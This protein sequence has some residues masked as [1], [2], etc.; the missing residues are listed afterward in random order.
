MTDQ[1]T[2]EA[3]D[4]ADLR[5]RIALAIHR[6]DNVH[7]LS[8]N[9][10]PSHHHYGE[11]DA[12]LAVRD[13]EMERMKVLVAASE[14]PGHA[15]RMAA[16]YADKAIENGERA[17]RLEAE[18]A[19]AR[20]FAAEMRDFCSPHAIAADYADRLVEAMDRAKGES[21]NPAADVLAAEWHR[22]NQRLE[23]LTES[24]GPE[25][26]VA[27]VE[28]VR[29][30]LVGLRGALGILLGGQVQGGTADLLG[31]AYYQEW[32]RRQ[33]DGQATTPPAL[34]EFQVTRV[35]DDVLNGV[36]DEVERGG[37]DGR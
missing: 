23:Q 37:E 9:D 33:G 29:G 35:S 1:A 32:R 30:E 4:R 7:A 27:I 10:I 34:A 6:Y 18:V 3:N 15:V 26:Q 31:W 5:R 24:K 11:A 16:Q 22:R 21:R 13:R 2:T 8:G 20:L 36:L 25:A 12:V 19:A 14:S 28:H 17:E